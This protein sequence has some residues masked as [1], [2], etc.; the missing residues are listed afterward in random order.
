MSK[1]LSDPINA[2][3]PAVSGE[4]GQDSGM[5]ITH[6]DTVATARTLIFDAIITCGNGRVIIADDFDRLTNRIV[7]DIK[8]LI[9]T[10]PSSPAQSPAGLRGGPDGG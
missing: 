10:A 2:N 9:I 1:S 7:A 4:G 8:H 5:E 6:A 3:S